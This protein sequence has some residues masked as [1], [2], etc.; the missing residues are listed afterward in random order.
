MANDKT[1]EYGAND[2]A[3]EVKK[4]KVAKSFYK[5]LHALA[6]NGG[7]YYPERKA[8]GEK[9]I[10]ADVIEMDDDTARAF[11]KDYVKKVNKNDEE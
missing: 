2:G 3:G 9:T 10:P 6:Y 11:G 5:V 1:I 4:G 7:Q 8:G